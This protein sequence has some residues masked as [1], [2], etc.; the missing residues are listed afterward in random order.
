MFRVLYLC[1]FLDQ[2]LQLPLCFGLIL[3]FATILASYQPQFVKLTHSHVLHSFP[4]KNNHNQDTHASL[5]YVDIKSLKVTMRSHSTSYIY[6]CVD[7]HK[8][9]R[10]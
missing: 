3:A 1:N 10:I 5:L 9:E 4:P 7:D 8:T 6:I 2:M